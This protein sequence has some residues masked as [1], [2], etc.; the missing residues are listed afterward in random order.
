MR[1]PPNADHRNAYQR[2]EVH[3]GG[4]HREH[5]VEVAH[6]DEFLVHRLKMLTDEDAGGEFLAPF[7]EVLVLL[8]ASSKEEDARVGM[9]EGQLTNDLVHQWSGVDLPLVGRKGCN[10]D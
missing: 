6:E 4:V 2:R 9:L 1:C 8:L 3:I 5:D 10:A 7:R